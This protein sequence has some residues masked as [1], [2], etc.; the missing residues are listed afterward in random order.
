MHLPIRLEKTHSVWEPKRDNTKCV[1]WGAGAA[2]RQWQIQMAEAMNPKLLFS[3]PCV[4]QRF[5]T[6]HP[7]ERDIQNRELGSLYRQPG[8]SSPLYS[9]TFPQSLSLQP[10]TF[11]FEDTPIFHKEHIQP[12]V[13]SHLGFIDIIFSSKTERLQFKAITDCS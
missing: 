6:C 9:A 2:W 12:L 4:P 1:C 11:G 5:G 10:I 3:L 13:F 7:Q 8:L